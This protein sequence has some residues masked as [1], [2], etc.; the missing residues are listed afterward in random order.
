MVESEDRAKVEPSRNQARPAHR[1]GLAAILQSGEVEIPKWV[2]IAWVIM[3]AVIVL[4]VIFGFFIYDK[5]RQWRE[6]KKLRKLPP[7]DC[8]GGPR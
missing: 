1:D 4:E 2:L 6:S 3:G 8:F 7:G 5:L